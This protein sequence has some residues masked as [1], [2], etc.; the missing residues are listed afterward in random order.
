[1]TSLN[2]SGSSHNIAVGMENGVQILDCKLKEVYSMK[3][4]TKGVFCM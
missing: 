1:M 4:E 2:Y 3:S